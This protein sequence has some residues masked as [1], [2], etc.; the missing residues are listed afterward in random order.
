MREFT[1]IGC[2]EPDERWRGYALLRRLLLGLL[3]PSL[4]LG[5]GCGSEEIP[6]AAE[7]ADAAVTVPAPY[8]PGPP[9]YQEIVRESLYVPMRDGVKLAVDVWLPEGLAPDARLPAILMQTRYWRSTG[10]RWPFAYF[11][12]RPGKWVALLVRHG[13][14]CV[15][16]DARGS[17][18]SFGTRPLEWSPDEVRDGAEIVDWILA[19]PW[20]NGVVGAE[21]ISYEGTTAEFLVTNGHPAVRAVIPRFSLFDAY[22]DIAFPGG[23]HLA[24]FTEQWR[25][26]NGMLDRN[27]IPPFAGLL[28]KIVAIGVRPV[29]ADRDRALR[30]AAVR[31]HADNYDVHEMALR[32]TFR[33]DAHMSG[34]L[35]AS[36]DTLSPSS[37]VRA[38]NAA[39]TPVYS[40]SGWFDVAYQHG[41]IKRHLTLTNPENRLILGPW[42]HA[43]RFT[44]SPAN[45]GRTRFDHAAE[46]LKF[47]DHHLKGRETGLS[48]DQRVHYFTMAEE[49][50][51]AAD[52][53]PPRSEARRFYFAANQ[54]LSTTPPRESEAADAYEVDTSHGTGPQSRWDS[55]IGGRFVAYPDRATQDEKLLVYDSEVLDRDTEVTGH[56]TVTLHVTSSAEDGAF[57]VYLEDVDAAGQVSYVTEGQLRAL[58]RHVSPLDPPYAHVVPYHSFT[59][60]DGRPL[61]PGEAVELR[62]DLLPTSYLFRQGHRIRVAVAGADKDHFALIPRD[63][64]PKIRVHREVRRPS[65]VVLPVVGR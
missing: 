41:A 61:V 34:G 24:R 29:D 44:S 38:L 11:L 49:R 16:V 7:P 13:Y 27:E 22:T 62:F 28:G 5:A 39:N 58:H 3:L 17:G 10:I 6:Q 12:D 48:A 4:L 43:G 63:G 60:A 65:H 2:A 18:A 50:W 37:Y 33:D 59:R 23:V 47:F 42:A 53:W 64:P 21:G 52:T 46:M 40:Y 55:A 56:P 54:T 15:S 9:R 51:K 57:F 20:S 30:A 1:V 36:I 19:Q 14:A 32:T 26:L 45:A 8:D 25:D 31:G 35:E